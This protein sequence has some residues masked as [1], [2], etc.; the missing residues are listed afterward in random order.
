MRKIRVKADLNKEKVPCTALYHGKSG[1]SAYTH[2]LNYQKNL[3]NKK[4]T[5]ALWRPS[6]P[7]HKFLPRC[8]LDVVATYNEPVGRKLQVGVDIGLGNQTIHSYL[9]CVVPTTRTERGFGR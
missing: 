2:E 3:V 6:L 5:N 7:Y 9:K 8:I 4:K 1:Y